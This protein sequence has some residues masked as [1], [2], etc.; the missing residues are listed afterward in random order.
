MVNATQMQDYETLLLKQEEKL[1]QKAVFL[2][3]LKDL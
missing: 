3:L 2:G 1:G